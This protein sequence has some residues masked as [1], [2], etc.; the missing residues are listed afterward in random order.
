MGEGER[1][2]L[3]KRSGKKEIIEGATVEEKAEKITSK[4]RAAKLIN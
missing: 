1:R 3:S 4:L 2:T